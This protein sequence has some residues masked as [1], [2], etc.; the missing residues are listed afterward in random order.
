MEVWQNFKVKVYLGARCSVITDLV[1]SL[2]NP[3]YRLESSL[4][5]GRTVVNS[6]NG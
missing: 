3:S 2:R 1:K 5:V 6:E 4:E